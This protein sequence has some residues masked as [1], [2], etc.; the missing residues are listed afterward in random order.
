MSQIQEY[1]KQGWRFVYDP[2]TMFIG[3][4]HPRGGNQSL[5]DL[6][7][8]LSKSV[9]DDFGRELE[10]F[11][12]TRDPEE[13]ED[14]VSMEFRGSTGCWHILV[15]GREA[16]ATKDIFQRDLFVAVLREHLRYLDKVTP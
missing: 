5:C 4:E 13:D 16:H 15:R 10:A 14:P 12:N 8:G 11:L 6:R 1:L 3:I 7:H 2:E 9:R